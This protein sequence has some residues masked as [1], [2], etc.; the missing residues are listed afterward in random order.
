M[1]AH[2]SDFVSSDH[3]SESGYP[4]PGRHRQ[5]EYW[6]V[7]GSAFLAFVVIACSWFW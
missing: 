7:V 6:P 1:E 2:P 3:W 5:L 4:Q